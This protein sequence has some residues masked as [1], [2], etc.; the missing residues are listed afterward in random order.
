MAKTPE[1]VLYQ[2]P[3]TD[4]LESI[5]PFCLKAHRLLNRKRLKFAVKDVLLPGEIKRVNPV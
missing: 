3:G 1:V 2:F 4:T 5:S